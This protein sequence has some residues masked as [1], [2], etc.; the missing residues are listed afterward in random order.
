MLRLIFFVLITFL[1]L[2]TSHAQARPVSYPGGWTLM[3]MNDVN[4]NSLHLHYSPSPKYSIGY[5]HEYL[6]DTKSHGDYIQLNNLIKRWNKKSS[7]ANLY[8]KSG[9]GVVYDSDDIE[10]AAF[11]GIA[12]DWEDRRFFV[13]YENKFFYGGDI[14]KYA[15][16]SARAGYAPY[17]GDFGDLHTWLMVQVDYDAGEEDTFSVT[18]LVRFFKGVQFLELG[19]NLDNGII[20]NYVHRF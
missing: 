12:T 11:T 6:R 3:V 8:L 10:E 5:R 20:A 14:E 2:G 13:S 18:P 15:H 9:I 19:Y 17:E 16:H 7:Q 4:H 1:H